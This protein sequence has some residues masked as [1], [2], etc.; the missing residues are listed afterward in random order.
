MNNLPQ[1]LESL[2]VKLRFHHTIITALTD[3][4]TE[5]RKSIM[6]AARVFDSDMDFDLKVKSIKP[7]EN[8]RVDFESVYY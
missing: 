7:P 6:H 2:R 8:V 3:S 4:N 5:M 1:E